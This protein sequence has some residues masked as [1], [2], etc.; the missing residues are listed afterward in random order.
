MADLKSKVFNNNKNNIQSEKKLRAIK[1]LNEEFKDLG[2]S[3]IYN[4]GVTVGLINEDNIFEWRFTL[5]GPKET[6]Y[7]L[8]MF[9]GK[10]IFSEDYPEMRPIISFITPIYHPNVKHLK[11]NNNNFPLLGNVSVSFLNGWK[12][13]TKIRKI[14]AKL[15]TIFYMANPECCYNKNIGKEYKEN[16]GLYELKVKYFTKKYAYPMQKLNKYNKDWDFIIDEKDPK[17]IKLKEQLNKDKNDGTNNSNKSID[18]N[19]VNKQIKKTNSPDENENNGIKLT[20]YFSDDKI[21][22]QCKS[23]DIIR[24]VFSRVKSRFSW[25]NISNEIMFIYCCKR[26][27]NM[28]ISIEDAGI[29]NYSWVL[30][31]D[32]HDIMYC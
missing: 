9:F 24:D 28:D 32:T 23:N 4:I 17:F 21:E 18:N 12:R 27:T 20:F 30:M 31:I 10:I 29:K 19:Q 15:Y 7:E 11:D 8:G 22:I 2:E 6:S 25:K 1:I 26:I 3:P 13:G 16:R 14:L 5:L